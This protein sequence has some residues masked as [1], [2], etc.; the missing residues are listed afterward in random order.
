M[1]YRHRAFFLGTYVFKGKVFDFVISERYLEAL[2]VSLQ[3]NV[4]SVFVVLRSQ[5]LGEGGLKLLLISFFYG[6]EQCNY[7]LRLGNSLLCIYC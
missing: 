4:P 1:N 6:L 5:F 7:W 2:L 3:D